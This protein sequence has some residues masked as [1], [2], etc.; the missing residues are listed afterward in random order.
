ML[1]GTQCP[2]LLRPKGSDD[3]E[4][5]SDSMGTVDE[6]QCALSHYLSERRLAS[7]TIL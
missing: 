3:W 5:C 7:M 4:H 1:Q 2:P 6:E